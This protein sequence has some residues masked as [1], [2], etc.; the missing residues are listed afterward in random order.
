V[1]RKWLAP[2]HSRNS[3]CAT[4]S[5]FTPHAFLHLLRCKL[6]SPAARRGFWQI[7]KRTS[8][9]SLRG[10][11]RSN[12]CRRVSGTKPTRG[13]D[14]VLVRGDQCLRRALYARCPASS[15][16]QRTRCEGESVTRKSSVTTSPRGPY[17]RR[18]QVFAVRPQRTIFGVWCSDS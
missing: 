14:Q 15:A 4:V 1:C 8:L 3:T 16:S 10:L 2:V 7:C 17:C 18:Q 11:S 13:I 9:Y 5:G 12:T 6:F